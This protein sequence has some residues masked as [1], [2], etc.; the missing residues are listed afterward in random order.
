MRK[1]IPTMPAFETSLIKGLTLGAVG[2]NLKRTKFTHIH[3]SDS[4]GISYRLTDS[5]TTS[6]DYAKD[7]DVK[8]KDKI[9]TFG[10]EYYM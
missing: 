5:V 10:L 4:A 8:G 2:K 3:K 7:K 9:T 6:V 1:T